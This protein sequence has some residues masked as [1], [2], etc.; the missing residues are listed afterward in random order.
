M[1]NIICLANRVVFITYVFEL[2]IFHHI[3]CF[4][5]IIYLVSFFYS[6]FILFIFSLHFILQ[7]IHIIPTCILFICPVLSIL[8]YIH[9]IPTCMLFICPV[10]SILLATL[11]V[12]PQ[13][14]YWGL[15][16]PTTPATTGPWLM[17]TRRENVW[18]V[19]CHEKD[20]TKV[21]PGKSQCLSDEEPP[22]TEMQSEW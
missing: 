15:P 9:V 5:N 18:I 10:L 21:S 13:I 17:P 4:K 14:S 8:L 16:A 3:E 6:P 7:Y 20:K 2:V 12:F 22:S 19:A 1:V 11:T